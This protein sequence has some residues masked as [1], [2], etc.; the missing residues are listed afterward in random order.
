MKKLSLFTSLVFLIASGLA[1]LGIAIIAMLLSV[2]DVRQLEKCFTTSMYEVHLCA[3]SDNYVKLKQISPYAIHAVIAAEDG[4]F[5][6]HEGFD[7]HEMEESLTANL[8]SGKIR[9]GGST[10]TQQLAKNIF[11]GKEKSLWRKL[12]EAYLAHAIERHY[13]KDFILEKYLN[14]VEFGPELYG[15]KPA[16]FHYFHKSP[17]DL[18]P[19]ES[20]YLA[21][22]LPNPK[23]YARSFS[24]GT[25][26][27]FNR[28]MVSIILKRMTSFGK[29][30]APAYQTAMHQLPNF[31]WVGLGLDSFA[32]TPNYS[33]DAVMPPGGI[34]EEDPAADEDALDEL[35]KEEQQLHSRASDREAT[36]PEKV[37][38]PTENSPAPEDA[39]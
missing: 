29:L 28:K 11:L 14:V 7:W 23:V 13:T 18:N 38:A 10:L 17:S 35:L 27:P 32:G 16:S 21:H 39:D 33:L 34:S 8:K 36:P 15:I 31:P 12:K 5:Y 4:G 2:P 24:A 30:S 22:L 19:L 3:T 20:A 6:S 37:H 1:L 25:L 26:T 9:R